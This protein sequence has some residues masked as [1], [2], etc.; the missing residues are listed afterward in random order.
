MGGSFGAWGFLYASFDCTLLGL[1]G[2]QDDMWNS[3]A[4]GTLTGGT[5]AIRQ[6][7]RQAA[8]AAVFGGVILGVIEGISMVMSNALASQNA[9]QAPQLEQAP[10]LPTLQ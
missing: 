1:R 7:P 2:G 9:P 8:G 6:G 5:L 4:A 10:D 3:I